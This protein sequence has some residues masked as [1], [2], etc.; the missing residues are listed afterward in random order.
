M[1][2]KDR[3][4]SL[5]DKFTLCA[6]LIRVGVTVKKTFPLSPHILCPLKTIW[7]RALALQPPTPPLPGCTPSLSTAW[8]K[9]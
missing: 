6:I 9:Q 1:D 2:D 5:Q 4:G 8:E 7:K 3:Q